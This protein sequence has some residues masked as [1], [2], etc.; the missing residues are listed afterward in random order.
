[1]S[2][3]TPIRRCTPKSRVR[4]LRVSSVSRRQ[5]LSIY[6]GRQP[7]NQLTRVKP[8]TIICRVCLGSFRSAVAVCLCQTRRKLTVDC[9]ITSVLRRVLRS[10]RTKP[11]NRTRTFDEQTDSAAFRYLNQ[12]HDE[13]FFELR[14]ECDIAKEFSLSSATVPR[15]YVVVKWATVIFWCNQNG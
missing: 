7:Q 13:I 8:V 5:P 11:R 10:R 3:T 14:I 6:R 12:R 1:M 9:L 2:T 4:H 15:K